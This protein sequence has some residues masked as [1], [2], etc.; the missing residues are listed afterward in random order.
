MQYHNT[1]THT[2]THVS[3]QNGHC[4]SK[5]GLRT[6]Q[7]CS[8]KKQYQPPCLYKGAERGLSCPSTMREEQGM[9]GWNGQRQ[10]YS[11]QALVKGCKGRKKILSMLDV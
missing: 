5:V 3:R 9:V 4:L 2:H 10:D 1:N 8:A 7:S 6:P 11:S